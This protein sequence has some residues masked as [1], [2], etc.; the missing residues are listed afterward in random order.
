MGIRFNA[1]F[2]RWARSAARIHSTA[3]YG[4]AQFACF[5]TP[6]FYLVVEPVPARIEDPHRRV[7]FSSQIEVDIDGLWLLVAPTRH[8]DKPGRW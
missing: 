3:A 7:A 4:A 2:R 1:R 5:A 8:R 6:A